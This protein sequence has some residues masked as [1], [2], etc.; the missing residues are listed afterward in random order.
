MGKLHTKTVNVVSCDFKLMYYLLKCF[1]N[2]NVLA[3]VDQLL[4]S[5]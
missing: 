2:R 4:L 3:V 5:F 1:V